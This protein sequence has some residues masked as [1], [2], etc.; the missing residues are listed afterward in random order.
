MGQRARPDPQ[1]AEPMREAEVPTLRADIQKLWRQFDGI[2]LC[3]LKP[4]V[5]KWAD[6][7]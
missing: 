2:I 7:F 6:V 3:G 4:I 5:K 1:A